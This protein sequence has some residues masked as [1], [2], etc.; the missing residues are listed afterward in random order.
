[1]M[2]WPTTDWTCPVPQSGRS[3]C[4]TSIP[5]DKRELRSVMIAR[6]SAPRAAMVARP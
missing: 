3:G 4:A 2:R 6:R 1:V 5:G